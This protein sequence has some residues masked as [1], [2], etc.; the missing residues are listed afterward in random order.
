MKSSLVALFSSLCLLGCDGRPEPVA[1]PAAPPVAANARPAA[2]AAN[3]PTVDLAPAPTHVAAAASAALEHGKLDWFQ[4]SF[5]ALLAEAARTKKIIFVDFW[6]SWCGWCKRLDKDTFSDD[7][8]VA[9]MKDILCYSVDA[10]SEAGVPIAEKYGAKSFPTLVFLEP[11]G[12]ERDRIGGYLPPDQFIAETQRVRRN[13]GTLPSLS[14]NVAKNPKDLFARLDYARKLA[15]KKDAEGVQTQL[16]EALAMIER[17]EGFDTQSIDD[18]S[19][20]LQRLGELGHQQGV[21][22]RLKAIELLDPEGKS[23]VR[24]R[25]RIEEI[26]NEM[27]QK[28]AQTQSF[29]TQ[30][31]RDF[32]AGEQYPELAFLGWG[33]V[34]DFERRGADEAR[35]REDAAGE[36]ALKAASRT[37]LAQAWRNRP[38][39]NDGR[40]GIFFASVYYEDSDDTTAEEKAFAIEMA[41]KALAAMPTSADHFDMLAC[42]YFAADRRADAL[43]TLDRG[44]VID[45]ANANLTKRREQ[46][47]KEN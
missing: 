16:T 19:K 42:S 47:A 46:F 24:R 21:Q 12:A 39:D 3:A 2:P 35:K 28:S 27:M 8:V 32:M 26:A 38:P 30:P 36:K 9:E 40:W 23:Q 22:D 25:I 45:A 17:G 6:T 31:L 41:E 34:F 1:P 5:D 33:T 4:G 11:D 43:A 13:E 37:A 29:D 7:A 20:L 18:Q 10:E 14:A 44:L 15:A